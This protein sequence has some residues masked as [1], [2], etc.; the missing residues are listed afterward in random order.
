MPGLIKD[1]QSKTDRQA[2]IKK[3]IDM[4]TN[5]DKNRQTRRKIFGWLVQFYRWWLLWLVASANFWLLWFVASI[6]GYF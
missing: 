6:D 5:R 3:L 4:Q 1:K 2:E